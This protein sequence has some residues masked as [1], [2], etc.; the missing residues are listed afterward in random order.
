MV[1]AESIKELCT[2]CHA[3]KRGP[4]LFEHP[5]VEENCLTCHNPHGGRT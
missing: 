1:K 5:P 3:D 2:T 4:W